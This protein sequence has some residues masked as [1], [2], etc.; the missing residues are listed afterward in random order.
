VNG[1]K[2]DENDLPGVS[3]KNIDYTDCGWG[4]GSN[5]VSW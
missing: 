1:Q 4:A 2:K 3:A 5:R